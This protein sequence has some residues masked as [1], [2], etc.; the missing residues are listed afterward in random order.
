MESS[1]K[2]SHMRNHT[3]GSHMLRAHI[4]QEHIIGK[5]DANSKGLEG[6]AR[7]EIELLL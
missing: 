1:L 6:S 3:T 7:E 5:G 2:L 4:A